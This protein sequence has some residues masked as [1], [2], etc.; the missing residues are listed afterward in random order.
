MDLWNEVLDP[1]D[2]GK[3]YFEVRVKNENDSVDMEFDTELLEE[4][5]AELM[6]QAPRC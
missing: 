6:S 2:Q 1:E 3:L 4:F 5:A